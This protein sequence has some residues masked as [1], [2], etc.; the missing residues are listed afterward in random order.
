MKVLIFGG[1]TEGR[2]LAELCAEKAEVY[3][4][5]TTEYGASLLNSDVNIIVGKKDEHE[6]ETLIK[7]ITPDIVT[8][9]THPYAELASLNIKNACMNTDTEYFRI[10]RDPLPKAENAVYVSSPEEAA[11]YLSDK[12]GKIFISTGTKELPYFIG[13]RDRSAVRI[14]DSEENISRCR[15]YGFDNIITGRGPF[16]EEE[17]I[18]DFKGSSYIITKESGRE[19]GFEEK[20]R[21]AEK[22]GAVPVFFYR[23]DRQP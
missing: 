8:D 4:C 14:L 1:T 16:S 7:E 3:V 11:E 23:S 22:T 6:I 19:G 17:N 21:A 5:V 2:E 15:E 12:D 18:R 10:I 9:A 20:I 13:L